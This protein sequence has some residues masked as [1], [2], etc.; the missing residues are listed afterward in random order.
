ML[1][2]RL[3]FLRGPTANSEFEATPSLSMSAPSREVS[4][5][6]ESGPGRTMTTGEQTRDQGLLQASAVS[7]GRGAID[8]PI[9]QNRDLFATPALAIGDLN[10]GLKVPVVCDPSCMQPESLDSIFERQ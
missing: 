6:R 5:P 7:F 4:R 2:Q 9:S 10:S 1:S 3:P 8:D